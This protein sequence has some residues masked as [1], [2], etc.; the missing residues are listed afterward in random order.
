MRL[1]VF[2]SVTAL[3]PFA[4]SSKISPTENPED[5]PNL[6]NTFNWSTVPTSGELLGGVPINETDLGELYSD[7]SE[8]SDGRSLRGLADGVEAGTDQIVDGVRWVYVGCHDHERDFKGRN[9]VG[10]DLKLSNQI[11]RA[12]DNAI[13]K[14]NELSFARTNYFAITGVKGGHSWRFETL[15]FTFHYAPEQCFEYLYPGTNQPSGGSGKKWAV[16]KKYVGGNRGSTM[17]KGT[18]L[19]PG[20]YLQDP[21]N[22]FRLNLQQDGNLVLHDNIGPVWSSNTAGVWQKVTAVY[23][24]NCA[25]CVPEVQVENVAPIRVQMN[26]N[27]NI[28]LYNKHNEVEWASGHTTQSQNVHAILQNDGNFVAISNFQNVYFATNTDWLDDFHNKKDAPG[29]EIY[30]HGDY[31]GGHM[32][33][34]VGDGAERR[35]HWELVVGNDKISSFKIRADTRLEVWEHGGFR[36]ENLVYREGEVSLSNSRWNDRISSLRVTKLDHACHTK[37]YRLVEIS[38]NNVVDE[39]G[40]LDITVDFSDNENENRHVSVYR[41]NRMDKSDT[42]VIN[43]DWTQKRLQSSDI[44]IKISEKD[45]WSDND[46]ELKKIVASQ[47]FL[48]SCDPVTVKGTIPTQSEIEKEECWTSTVTVG[49][50]QSTVDGTGS[51]QGEVSGQYQKCYREMIPAR[52]YGYVVEVRSAV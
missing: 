28:I 7:E 33:I 52:G 6:E 25:F 16:W 36:G 47:W 22:Q 4:L 30:E 42:W 46:Y 19:Q 45:S 50:T 13:H 24:P 18:I 32:F 20:D 31:V 9:Y 29:V 11:A 14:E 27:G 15:D 37:E 38:S 48:N 5:I 40:K 10:H 41:N 26:S 12:K 51:V 35:D 39:D 1:S 21:S 23:I 44:S 49:G 8:N 3:V 17:T 34:G 2:F 43:S